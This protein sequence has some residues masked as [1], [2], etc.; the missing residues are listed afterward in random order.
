M[1]RNALSTIGRRAWGSQVPLETKKKAKLKVAAPV[2]AGDRPD[3]FCCARACCAGVHLIVDLHG[4]KRLDDIDHIE[5]D[6]AAAASKAAQ[7]TLLHIHLHHF[8]AER[9]IGRGGAGRKPHIHP[10]LAGFRLCRAGRVPC[11]A[12]ANPDACPFR[13]F[14]RSVFGKPLFSVQRNLARTRRPERFERL[15]GLPAAPGYPGRLF[16]CGNEIFGLSCPTTVRPLGGLADL[17][18]DGKRWIAETLFD[19]LRRPA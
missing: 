13:C 8:Q 18:P 9:R 15:L 2:P 4:A 7:A 3:H 19:D 6:A 10:Y 17:S 11:A 12:S 5:G 16:F 14:A 1:S